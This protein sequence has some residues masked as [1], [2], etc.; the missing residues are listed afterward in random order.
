MPALADIV[1]TLSE[2]YLQRQLPSWLTGQAAVFGQNA[3]LN[4]QPDAQLGLSASLSQLGLP[5]AI[6]VTVVFGLSASEGHLKLALARVDMA[7]FNLPADMIQSVT[8]S[9]LLQIESH[10]NE[11]ILTGAAQG[12]RVTGVMTDDDSLT[13]LLNPGIG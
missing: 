11:A 8:A 6:P 12:M 9:W 13:L 3:V 4:L 1:V 5:L 7:G 10:I 2:S